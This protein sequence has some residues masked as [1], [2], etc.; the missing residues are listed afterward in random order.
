[1]ANWW[2]AKE[3]ERQQGLP[4]CRKVARTHVS[5]SGW[6]QQQRGCVIMTQSNLPVSGEVASSDFIFVRLHFP[7]SCIDAR[8]ADGDKTSSVFSLL[9]PVESLFRSVY[10]LVKISPLWK[11]H[12]SFVLVSLCSLDQCGF[13]LLAVLALPMVEF[14]Y[15]I[16]KEIIFNCFTRYHSR[17]FCPQ[18]YGRKLIA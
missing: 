2:R 6:T 16:C 10:C 17:C 1:M 11:L 8:L 14:M 7:A 15:Q 4:G 13:Y 9:C 12:L 3:R 18:K 5:C